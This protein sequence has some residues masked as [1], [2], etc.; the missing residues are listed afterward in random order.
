MTIWTDVHLFILD[1]PPSPIL[2][3]P[4]P[5]CFSFVPQDQLLL[6]SGIERFT[7]DLALSTTPVPGYQPAY[8]EGFLHHIETVVKEYKRVR[9][10]NP[11]RLVLT[12]PPMAGKT[13]LAARLARA[14]SLRHITAKDI[15]EYAGKASPDLQ[16]AVQ[17]E[18]SG[19]EPRASVKNMAALL[20]E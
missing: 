16:K 3:V 4:S 18:M 2:Y 19:K 7:L 14:Y 13:A 8:R 1:S 5:P 17:A 9:N 11:L 15:L 10:V 12:G 6:L 20:Q